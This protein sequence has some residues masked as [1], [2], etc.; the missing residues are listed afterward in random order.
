M[1]A[2]ERL[3][4]SLRLLQDVDTIKNSKAKSKNILTSDEENLIVGI[5]EAKI[6]KIMEDDE[7]ALKM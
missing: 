4:T 3:K 6:K 5:T 2:R 1:K 7:Y